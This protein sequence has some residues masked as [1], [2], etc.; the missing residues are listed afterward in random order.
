MKQ[1]RRATNVTH[2][3]IVARWFARIGPA[4]STRLTMRVAR[5]SR[6]EQAALRRRSPSRVEA[7]ARIR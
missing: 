7:D 2:H 5:H 1:R 3:I 6:R 4:I